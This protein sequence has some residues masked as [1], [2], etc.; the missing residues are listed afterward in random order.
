LS[1]DHLR[2]TLQSYAAYYNKIRTGCGRSVLGRLDGLP[3]KCY[4]VTNPVMSGMAA[5]RA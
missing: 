2:K 5:P 1:E 3:V 4:I